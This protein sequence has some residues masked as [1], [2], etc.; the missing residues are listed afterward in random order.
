MR[1]AIFCAAATALSFA[2]VP[3]HSQN[4]YTLRPNHPMTAIT[5]TEC[6]ASVRIYPDHSRWIDGACSRIELSESPS[7]IN[8]HFVTGT[9]RA[10]YILPAKAKGQRVLPVVGVA[11]GRSGDLSVSDVQEGQCEYHGNNGISCRALVRT[12]RKSFAI[13]H[14]AGF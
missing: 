3:V 12:G 1:A 7:S 6:K 4:T 11:V 14:A 5:P 10:V 8:I 13:V 2:V 9:A